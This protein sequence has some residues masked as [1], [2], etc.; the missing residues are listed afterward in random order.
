MFVFY[1]KLMKNYSRGTTGVKVIF[2]YYSHKF[3][4][5][6]YMLK[7]FYRYRLAYML[8][9]RNAFLWM[10]RWQSLRVLCLVL[11]FLCENFYIQY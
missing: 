6:T 1:L 11:T 10:T 7:K 8:I 4:K 5:T 2:A 9:Y 3:S